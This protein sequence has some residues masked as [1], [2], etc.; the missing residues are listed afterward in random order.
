[1]L[2]F[3]TPLRGA[4]LALHPA[5]ALAVS[6]SSSSSPPSSYR[7]TA[8]VPSTV[9]LPAELSAR[10]LALQLGGVRLVDV[11]KVLCVSARGRSGAVGR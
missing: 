3:R 9:T 8:K 5:R 4:S 1:M 7:R 11:L 6:S 10:E 2:L